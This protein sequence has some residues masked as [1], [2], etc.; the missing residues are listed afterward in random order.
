MA[1]IPA[2]HAPVPTQKTRVQPLQIVNGARPCRPSA[3]GASGASETR[4]TRDALHAS[5]SRFHLGS[6][7][8]GEIC[9]LVAI[10]KL[11]FLVAIAAYICD[12]QQYLRSHHRIH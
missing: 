1:S 10:P 9:N 4:Y 6:T 7:L 5:G 3:C 8:A 11:Y 12:P 2:L